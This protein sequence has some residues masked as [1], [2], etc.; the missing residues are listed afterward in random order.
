[1][2]TEDGTH[3]WTVQTK[4]RVEW[5]REKGQD[6]YYHLGALTLLDRTILEREG[7]TVFEHRTFNS[8]LQLETFFIVHDLNRDGLSD[9]LVPLHNLVMWN[10]W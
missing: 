4:L 1:M 3:R 6:G 10:P 5:T 2:P 7:S 8:S 9:I